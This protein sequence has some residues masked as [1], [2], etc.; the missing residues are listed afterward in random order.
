MT[1][2]ITVNTPAFAHSTGS[3]FGTAASVA[4]IMPELY[5]LVTTSTPSTP[6]ASWAN[7]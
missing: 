5:S 7:W 4:R 1:S 2:V 3:R 6:T